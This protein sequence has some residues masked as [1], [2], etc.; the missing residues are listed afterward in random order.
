MSN[1]LSDMRVR[2]PA[3]TSN[4]G[5]GF[6]VLGLGLGMYLDL[7][8]ELDTGAIEVLSTGEG[9]DKLPTDESNLIAQLILEHA[10]Q[11]RARGFRV[12]THS[13]IPL[14]RGFG[15]SASA[16]VGALALMQLATKGAIDRQEILQIS[17]ALEGHPDNVS[18]SIYGGLTISASLESGV[19][20]HPVRIPETLQI[21]ALVPDREVSTSA[22][23]AALPSSYERHE[24]VFNLQRL[25]QLLAGLYEGNLE[26]IAAGLN[27]RLHQSY[28][29]G[30][31]PPMAEAIDAMKKVDG[32]V[33]AFVSGAGPAIVAFA[34]HN[35]E[36][37]GDAGKS[38][39]QAAG[40]DAFTRIVA[41]DY[42]GVTQR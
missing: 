1:D 11:L 35:A 7:S 22:A 40:I 39:F 37:I 24:V 29:C 2:V 23:R 34:S 17:T 42:Q 38:L 4:L 18:A 21:V 20:T 14:T 9:A 41:P 27:D 6:D 31:L 32:C 10:P 16:I 30:L 15:S 19:T 26:M 12:R 25:G 28:R 5:S 8:L 33:G 13:D 3:S 36:Q